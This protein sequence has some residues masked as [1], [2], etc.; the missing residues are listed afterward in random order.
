MR[1][2]R[3]PSKMS[4][5]Q[6]AV[7]CRFIGAFKPPHQR[8]WCGGKDA[9]KW[10]SYRYV[11]SAATTAP[12]QMGIFQRELKNKK[13]VSFYI[14]HGLYWFVNVLCLL[15][16]KLSELKRSWIDLP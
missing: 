11:S 10:A 16:P 3:S 8:I 12:Q 15:I 2:F 9:P 14:A 4:Q 1:A 13:A 7:V 6:G 5:M